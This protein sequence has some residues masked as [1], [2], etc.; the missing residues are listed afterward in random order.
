MFS[1]NLALR[2]MDTAI[3]AGQSRFRSRLAA[4]FLSRRFSL[5]RIIIQ[6]YRGHARASASAR[7][8]LLILARSKEVARQMQ[9]TVRARKKGKA[10]S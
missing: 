6:L 1:I 3:K 2:I 9:I 7:N 5:A 8:R 4:R 10:T